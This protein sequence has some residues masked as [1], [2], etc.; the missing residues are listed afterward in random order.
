MKGKTIHE[1]K[2]GDKASVTKTISEQDVYAFAEITGDFNPVH[3]DQEYAATTPFKQRIAHGALTSGLLSNVLGMKLPGVGCIYVSSTVKFKRP[4]F[5]N[6]T[7]T[8]EAEVAELDV[9]KNRVRLLTRCL[10]QKNETVLEGEAV[11]LA[12]R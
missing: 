2:V 4:V 7:I 1:M 3:V 11:L 6:D 10:N 9:E 12:P 8:A 5:F